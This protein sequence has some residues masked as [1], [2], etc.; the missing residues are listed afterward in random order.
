MQINKN[1]IAFFSQSGS[2]LNNIIYHTGKIPAAIITNRQNDDGIN[3]SLKQAKDE[4]KLNWITLPK[5]PE[6]K[7][8]KNALKPFK[9]PLITLHGYLRIIPKEICKKYKEIYNLHPGLITEYP[10]LKGKDPQIRAVQAG[11][12][13]AGAV[14]HRV[15]SEVDAGEVIASYPIYIAGLDEEQVIDRLHS[16]G[17]IMWYRFFNDYEHR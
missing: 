6:L 7:D 4:G 16:L 8:Y 5:N 10:E 14:I 11:H 13:I 9:N 1:W 2:E 3:P 15:I 17:S 12:K